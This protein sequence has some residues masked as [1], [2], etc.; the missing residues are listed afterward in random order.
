MS[1][2][3]AE[4]QF[5]SYTTAFSIIST[6]DPGGQ[7]KAAAGRIPVEIMKEAYTT[8]LMLHDTLGL[9]ISQNVA[10]EV[11]DHMSQ[12]SVH[13]E[14]NALAYKDALHALKTFSEDDCND[15]TKCFDDWRDAL[16]KVQNVIDQIP[17]R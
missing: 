11:Y 14:R 4:S 7:G 15:P 16:E 10:K 6:Q 17:R 2:I 1:S 9:D 5:E 3:P 13:L 8:L 12:Y